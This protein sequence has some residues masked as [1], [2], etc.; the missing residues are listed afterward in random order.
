VVLRAWS[1]GEQ[2]CYMMANESYVGLEVSGVLYS[3]YYGSEGT[4]R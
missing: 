2:Q 3:K 4:Q 1:F